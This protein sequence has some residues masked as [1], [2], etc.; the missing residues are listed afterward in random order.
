[1]NN[2]FGFQVKEEKPFASTPLGVA[3]NTVLGLPKTTLDVG[4]SIGRE[5]SRSIGSAGVTVA[6][7][8]GGQDEVSPKE[9]PGNFRQSMFETVFGHEPVRSIEDRVI[10]AEST[11][12]DSPFAQRTGLD[13]MAT[14]LAFTGVMGMTAL[15]LSPVGSIQ[16]NATKSLVKEVSEQGAFKLLK[17]MRVEDD[18][19]QRFAP[20]FAK[21]KTLD[22]V[23]DIW[24]NMQAVVGAKILDRFPDAAK[25]T[26]P[27]NPNLPVSVYKIPDE[28]VQAAA[29]TALKKE[30][31]DVVDDAV[32]QFVAMRTMRDG[33]KVPAIRKDSGIFAPKEF[34]NFNFK[35]LPRVFSSLNFRDAAFSF[36]NLTARQAAEEGGFGPMV[37]LYTNANQAFA[38]RTSFALERADDIKTLATG[39]GVKIN[40]E[41]GKQLFRALEGATD[42]SDNIKKLARGVRETLNQ[43]RLDANV[44]RQSLGKKEIGFIDNYAPHLQE[45]TFWRKVLGDNKTEI[46]DNFDFIIPNAKKNPHALPRTGQMAE[47]ETNAWKLLDSYISSIADDLYTSPVIEQVKAV[48]SVLKG[49][50][51]HNMSNAIQRFVRENLVGKPAK[52]DSELGLVEGTTGRAIV[53]RINMARNVAALAGNLVWSAFVQPASAIMTSARAGGATRGIQNTLGG[54]LDF[55][56]DASIRKQVRELP[57]LVQKTK[58]ASIARSGMGD[59]DKT[60]TRIF[61][62]KIDKYND[63][64]GKVADSVEYWLTGTASAAGYRY[65]KQLGLKGKEADILADWLGGAT[66]SVYTKEARPFL[67]NN[68]S[69][70]GAFPFQTYAFE[71]YRYVKTLAGR[72]GGLP[73]EQSDRVNQG[74]MLLSGMWLYNQYSEATTGRKLNTI[75]SAIPI[76]GREV[77]NQ[78]IKPINKLTGIPLPTAESGFGRAPIA[79][80]EDIKS[81]ITAFQPF[82]EN[83]NI[84]PLRKELIRWG[85]GFSGAAGAATVNRFVDGLIASMDG[86][87][88]DRSGKSIFKI[89]GNDKIIAPILGP[90]STKAG[91]DYLNRG[92][93]NKDNRFGF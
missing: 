4:K 29:R 58:G 5:I 16:K 51:Y 85:M 44:V 64:I 13:K 1:M 86:V 93:E 60:A 56:T 83:G 12:K 55:T 15:D 49:R 7:R 75:G 72:P 84:Q 43:L 67:L 53:Q 71:L 8:F 69:V 91:K 54:I 65:A 2:R 20:E 36:D 73:L 61:S 57:T 33:R 32:N 11:I 78:I 10:S 77:E 42:V 24:G 70:R 30:S 25:Y 17:S 27:F 22:E 87:Q 6:K 76:A 48:D 9:I 68:L 34:E 46:S 45:T 3:T 59:L 79:P 90:Y 66:Q 37:K 31:V 38:D 88:K 18:I 40:K 50:G 74:I 63:V 19:A 81:L 39:A 35:D 92:T 47:I 14:S 62:S 21:A 52:I 89:R 23:S 41:T 28:S 82:V 80:L 26:N